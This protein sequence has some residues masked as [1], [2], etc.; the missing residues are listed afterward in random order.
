MSKSKESN[1]NRVADFEAAQKYEKLKAYLKD[2]G[3]VVVAFSGGVDSSLLLAAAGDALGEKALSV[4]AC[5]PSFPKHEKEQAEDIARQLGTK[6]IF[7]N[8]NEIDLPEYRA[9]PPERCYYCK[10]QLFGEIKR[11]SQR[12]SISN[13]LDGTNYD[14]RFDIRPGRKAALELGIRSP[15]LELK[16]GKEMIH[17]MARKR[18]LPNWDQPPCA[19]LASRIPYG[20]EITPE[21]LK[22]IGDTEQKIKDLGFR[23]VRVRDHGDLARIEVG[24]SELDTAC[25]KETRN[26]L[27][28][29][30]KK[31]GYSFVCLDLEGYRVGS[32]N[33]VLDSST[34]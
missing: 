7:F 30:C 18:G 16:L 5:S 3:G 28:E 32:M 12:E 29:I 17:R 31:Q 20:Q 9:N 8:S 1:L 19:C 25:K 15:L 23:V 13:I 10:H 27:K 4:T 34:K 24:S 21:R 6:H 26:I 11:I 14:D 22:R 2:M 33:E